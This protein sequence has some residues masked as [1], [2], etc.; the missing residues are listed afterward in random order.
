MWGGGS[1]RRGPVDRAECVW[2]EVGEGGR[3]SSVGAV[4]E[5]LLHFLF[6]LLGRRHGYVSPQ[7]LVEEAA[8]A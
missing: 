8:G 3:V 1:K 5:E 4:G 7:Q 6:E 2:I